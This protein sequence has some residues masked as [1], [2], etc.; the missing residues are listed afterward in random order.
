MRSR[1][2]IIKAAKKCH[3]KYPAGKMA[4]CRRFLVTSYCGC[5]K[6]GGYSN[7][8]THRGMSKNARYGVEDLSVPV[9]VVAAVRAE[10]AQLK[11]KQAAGP[12]G[13]AAATESGDDESESKG[14]SGGESE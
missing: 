11:T 1:F 5:L 12:D 10:L 6:T 4:A 9:S 3:S 13:A 8:K 7:Y 2:D 14:E